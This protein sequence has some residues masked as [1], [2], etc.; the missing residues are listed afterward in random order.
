MLSR[1]G[2][3]LNESNDAVISI[4]VIKKNPTRVAQDFLFQEITLNPKI[5]AGCPLS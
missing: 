4:I 3:K 2:P 5:L 1:H